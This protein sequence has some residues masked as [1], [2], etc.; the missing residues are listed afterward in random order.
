MEQYLTGRTALVTGA[1]WGIGTACALFYAA[2][3]A[4]VVVSDTNGEFVSTIVAGI[5]GNNGIATFIEADLSD[6][7]A[8]EKLVERTISIYGSIDIACNNSALSAES[9]PPVYRSIEGLA[10]G[11]D[12]KLEGLFYCMKFEA[13]AMHKKG[14]GVIVNMS[15]LP[16]VAGLSVWSPEISAKFALATSKR[17]DLIYRARG[18]R[19]NTVSPDL[20]RAALLENANLHEGS[21]AAIIPHAGRYS[22]IEQV[23]QL[24]LWLSL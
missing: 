10:S 22:K 15:C 11:L 18:V 9:Q 21:K 8:C 23:I 7:W 3:G 4:R 14:G 24:V 16:G 1:G 13:A 5:K 2:H 19:I 17:H 6:P 20:V 12:S